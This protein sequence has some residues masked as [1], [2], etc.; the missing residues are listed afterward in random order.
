MIADV[1]IYDIIQVPIKVMVKF[2]FLPIMIVKT[3]VTMLVYLG[4]LNLNG[5][6]KL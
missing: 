4:L 5:K 3:T 1:M 2:G 6:M